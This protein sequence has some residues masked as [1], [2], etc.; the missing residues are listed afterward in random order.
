MKKN[1]LLVLSVLFF[2]SHSYSQANCGANVP[3]FNVDFTGLASG[4]IWQSPWVV[5]NDTACCGAV[6]PNRCLKF[7]VTTD[8]NTTGITLE[9]MYGAIPNGAL[10]FQIDCGTPVSFSD[11]GS[12]TPGIHEVTFC[13][14]GNNV[15]GYRITSIG[16]PPDIAGQVYLDNNSNC[17]HDIGEA[18]LQNIPVNLLDNLL[19]VVAISYTNLHGDFSFRAAPGTYTLE[20]TAAQ[21][22]SA[23]YN[24][25]CPMSG[26]ISVPSIPSLNNYF[27]LTCVAATFDLAAHLNSQVFR[28]GAHAYFYPHITNTGC[29]PIQPQAKLILDDTNITYLSSLVP[30][31]TISGDTLIWNVPISMAYNSYLSLYFVTVGVDT[32][33]TIGDTVCATFIVEPVAGDANPANNTLTFCSS[34]HSSYD[35][36]EKEVVPQG[37]VLPNTE[38]TYTIYFQNTGND[39][40]LDIFII[41][42]IST[43][44]DIR[45][46]QPIFSSHPYT[47]Q[48]Y[49]GNV[50]RF[51]FDNIYLPDSNVNEPASHGFIQYKIHT[52]P[53]LTTGTQISNT[54]DI[55]FDF[56]PAVVTNTTL[57]VINAAASIGENQS[58]HISVYPNPATD[59]L[60][61]DN[62]KLKIESVAIYDVIGKPIL[63]FSFT[64][65]LTSA[66]TSLNISLIS[67][68]IYFVRI[69]TSSGY[70]TQKLIIQH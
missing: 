35:P 69:K 6:T 41:D 17:I 8:T 19:N 31:D 20:I 47:V 23:G 61:I 52:L 70:N 32:T 26:Q 28:P 46:F 30:P 27:G 2:V 7:I 9:F 63:S 10:Y 11:T 3:V 13:K 40:A 22:A 1:L 15:N 12:I 43:N 55:Y 54:A 16:T 57:N 45:T 56:N 4:T 65:G 38:F 49:S 58:T 59:E 29:T 18:Y 36:N 42:T 37:D 44:L 24:L 50:V 62:G 67:S 5:R 53:G 25:S 33:A 64:K 39:T 48:V 34:V 60:K 14:P 68:G 21:A 51:I 66:T